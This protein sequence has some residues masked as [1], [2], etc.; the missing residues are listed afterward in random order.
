MDPQT[1]AQGANTDATMTEAFQV[2]VV[3]DI[4]ANLQAMMASLADDQIKVLTAASG[5]QALELLLHHDVGLALLDVQMPGMDGYE[6]AELM[7]GTSR[8]RH[9]PIVFL[10]AGA[11]D[12]RVGFRGYEAGAVDF[13]YKPVDVRVLK[14]KIKVFMDLDRQ[15][16]Q[17]ALRMA[18][19]QRV[20]RLNAMML[21]ALSHDI[22]TPLA[23]LTLN[24]EVVMRRAELPAVK[25]AG[26]RIKAAT[27]MLSRHV[28]HLV[29]LASL[30]M[31]DLRPELASGDLAALVRLRMD[32]EAAE[33]MPDDPPELV[34][35]GDTS[36]RFDAQLIGRAVD[37]LL[38]LAAIHGAGT[39]VQVQVDGLKRRALS[40]RVSMASVLPQGVHQHLFGGEHA[41][42]GLPTPKVG[43]GLGGAEQVARAHGGSLIGSSNERDGTLFELVLPRDA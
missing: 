21:G 25:Q 18:D 1:L 43:A 34:V 3:D 7:R 10:T 23:A 35:L 39:P 15:R 19:L 37:Q 28:D 27:T 20:S 38:L 29:N 30:P 32:A 16:R 42:P 26:E 31:G 41:A 11:Q 17:I 36:G 9:V 6:L 4:A 22:R 40:M 14:A 12:D 13:L 5:A 33:L 8:T 24:A 2:L